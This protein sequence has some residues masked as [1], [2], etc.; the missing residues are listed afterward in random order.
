MCTLTAH[1]WGAHAPSATG[2]RLLCGR[3]L[4]SCCRPA[5]RSHLQLMPTRGAMRETDKLAM[6][7]H[8]DA[9]RGCAAN[10]ELVA[11]WGR[12]TV[13]LPVNTL[14]QVNWCVNW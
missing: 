6:S 8:S 11:L 5:Q 9:Q 2:A 13:Y 4:L 14:Q 12:G 3:V 10:V 1:R 7:T